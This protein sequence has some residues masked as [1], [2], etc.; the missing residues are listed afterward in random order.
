[1]KRIAV[2]AITERGCVLGEKIASEVINIDLL[3]IKKRENWNSEWDKLSSLVKDSFSKYDGFIFI[4]AVGI[5]VRMI[6]KIIV[7]KDIDPAIVVV[8]E[9]GQNTISLLSGHLGGGNNLTKELSSLLKN[10]PVI[11]TAT[12]VNDIYSI[13]SFASDH[14]LVIEPVSNIVKFNKALL[15]GQEIDIIIDEGIDIKDKKNIK[16]YSFHDFK[17]YKKLD[18]KNLKAII[19]NKNDFPLEVDI[20]LRP[21]NI[22]LGVGCK[23]NY[24]V[25]L[26]EKNILKLFSE[27]NIS[28]KSIKEIRSISIK[29]DEECIKNISCKYNIP[30]KTFL[31]DEL[32]TV[33]EEHPDLLKSD[34]VFKNTGTYGVAEPSALIA[35]KENILLISK[36]TDMEGMTVA[37]SE[38]TPFLLSKIDNKWL[39]RKK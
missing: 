1:M 29:K 11:T 16:E 24:P 2:I 4:M 22:I 39:R 36:R 12:D 14:A 8:D 25:N 34:F 5:V 23:K 9:Q 19:T 20:Y 38:K 13:D 17:E 18:N 27:K 7:S 6:S 31:A 26:F 32:N 15:N 21:K 28:I 37:I 35:D 33:F 30:F 3:T 10:N